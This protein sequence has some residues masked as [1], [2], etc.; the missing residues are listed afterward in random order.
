M[1]KWLVII[2]LILILGVVG[3]NYVYQD[4]RNISE[5]TAEFTLSADEIKNEFLSDNS[6][7]EAKYLNKTVIVNGKV[8]EI[9]M[10]SITLNSSV[11]CQLNNS[12][13]KQLKIG[14]NTKI[15]GRII[16]YDDLLEQIKMDQCTISE[17]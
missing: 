5:E 16:G 4:H 15:K 1:K 8:S 14:S 10:N 3:Y 13:Y 12:D 11:F 17:Y 7:S 2:I 9:D 6:S